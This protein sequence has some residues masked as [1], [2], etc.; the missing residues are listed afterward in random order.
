MDQVF[1][2]ASR[3]TGTGP[4]A[5]AGA[6]PL[7]LARFAPP[8][9]PPECQSRTRQPRVVPSVMRGQGISCGHFC[10]GACVRIQTAAHSFA[11]ART[12]AV[13]A[14]RASSGGRKAGG[15]RPGSSD[16][17]LRAPFDSHV[18]WLVCRHAPQGATEAAACCACSGPDRT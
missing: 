4:R 1:R 14:S 3:R 8:F 9:A 15:N 5:P 10:R 6:R 12:Q 7:T 13:I 11:F 2:C 16:G 18:I 17:N